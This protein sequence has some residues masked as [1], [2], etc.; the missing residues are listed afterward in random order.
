MP[1]LQDQPAT[2]S[3]KMLS[4]EEL[5]SWMALSHPQVSIYAKR[6]RKDKAPRIFWC[7]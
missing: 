7:S 4:R 1:N 6:L 2:G 3:S 5:E